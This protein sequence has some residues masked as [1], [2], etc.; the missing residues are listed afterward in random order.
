[1]RD[2]IPPGTP[3]SDFRIVWST[4]SLLRQRFAAVGRGASIDADQEMAAHFNEPERR[5]R[6]AERVSQ[7][8]DG[9][10]RFAACAVVP[11]MKPGARS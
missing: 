3:T 6:R 9:P 4:G 10:V 7:A 5:I 2:W 11:D 1:M 8:L